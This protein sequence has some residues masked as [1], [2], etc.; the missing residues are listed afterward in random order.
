MNTEKIA[1]DNKIFETLT[2]SHA[3]GMNTPESDV[4]YRGIFVA[5]KENVITGLFPIEQWQDPNADRVLFELRKYIKLLSDMNPNIL[6][7]VWVDEKFIQYD[8]PT[9]QILRG[10]RDELLSSKVKHT[11]SG[12]AHSQLRRI[13]G[14]V[15]YDNKTI[16]IL[17]HAFQTGDI[18]DLWI[19]S[20]FKGMT[21]EKLIQTHLKIHKYDA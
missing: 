9:Y 10:M 20:N 16:D 19:R 7:L 21:K 5:P 1:N 2:G 4:D 8:S 14:A 6:E 18:D 15:V 17:Y 12:Y 13:R 3:Y 11:F